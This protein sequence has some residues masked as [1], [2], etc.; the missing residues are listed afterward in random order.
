MTDSHP[1]HAALVGTAAYAET[2]NLTWSQ[3]AGGATLASMLTWGHQLP[4]AFGGKP[5]VDGTPQTVLHGFQR[6]DYQRR[7]R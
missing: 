4:A 3:A 5:S 2:R 1:L 6:R 7:V